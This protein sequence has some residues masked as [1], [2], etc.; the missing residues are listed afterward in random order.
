MELSDEHILKFQTI[1]RN[2]FGIEI[3]KKEAYEK[4]FKLLGL[5]SLIRNSDSTKIHEKHSKKV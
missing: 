5:L 1:Y 2:R 3:G 4:A